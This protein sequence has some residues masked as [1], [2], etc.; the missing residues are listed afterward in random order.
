MK[1][2]HQGSKGV[3]SHQNTPIKDS[4]FINI[5]DKRERIKI[6]IREKFPDHTRN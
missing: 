1:K 3:K 4:K 2:N 5:E 6:V